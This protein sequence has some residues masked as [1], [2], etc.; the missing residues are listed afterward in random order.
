MQ[1]NKAPSLIKTDDNKK[2]VPSVLDTDNDDLCFVLPTGS[3]TVVSAGRSLVSSLPWTPLGVLQCGHAHH[4]NTEAMQKGCQAMNVPYQYVESIEV[5]EQFLFGLPSLH[6]DAKVVLWDAVW[7]PSGTVDVTKAPWNNRR[8]MFGPHDFVCPKKSSWVYQPVA[9]RQTGYFYNALSEW[10]L[11]LMASFGPFALPFYSC[12]FPVVEHTTA[13]RDALDVS[14]IGASKQLKLVVYFKNRLQMELDNAVRFI[15]T[16]L[17]KFLHPEIQS[18]DV[19]MVRHGSYKHDDFIK[20]VTQCH[21]V[22]WIGCHESQGFAF[23]D[24]LMM[25]KPIFCWNVKS[26]YQ[27][28]NAQQQSVY[29]GAYD[30]KLHPMLATSA[31]CWQEGVTGLTAYTGVEFCR[32]LIAFVKRFVVSPDISSRQG[33]KDFIAKRLASVPAMQRLFHVWHMACSTPTQN[34]KFSFAIGETK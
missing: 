14:I 32:G 21:A 18:I 7:I 8:I 24:V 30:E 23:Q 12:P 9:A 6:G 15:Q 34:S 11:K 17:A 4:R 1:D 31:T 25:N 5:A 10:T 3:T 27:E 13:T 2:T 29:K 33:P 20:L 26:M 22:V 16:Q 28:R 19:Q